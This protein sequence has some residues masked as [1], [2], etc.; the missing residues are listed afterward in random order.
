[1]SRILIT[2]AEGF[3]GHYLAAALHARGH[4]V[5]G[6]VQCESPTARDTRSASLQQT[7]VC[8]LLDP[9]G[10]SR[11]V[12]AVRPDKV[13][14]LA[15]IAFVGHGDVE[16]IYR[17]N[18]VGT[19]HLLA[20]LA[21]SGAPL[22]AVLLAS[23]AHVYGN[24]YGNVYA[25]VAGGELDESVALA[26]ANDYAVSKLAMEYMARTWHEH[27]PITIV[28]PFNYTGIGQSEDYLLPK[29]VAHFRRRAPLIELGNLDVERDFSD[30][31]TVVE[32]YCRLLERQAAHEV[33]N[34]CSGRGQSL[35]GVFE[36]VSEMAGYR[37]EVRMNP[38]FVRA[39]EVLRLVGSKAALDRCIGPVAGPSIG[40]TLAWMFNA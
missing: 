27:L 3:T 1:M 38:A 17:V 40:E 20:A 7:H 32:V 11:V 16:A 22:T 35:R 2:G 13:A 5:H 23:S 30:V 28:R 31:R 19:R 8:D 12:N 29:I 4:E 18:V 34:V 26:P 33:F 37:P 9:I 10:L 6:L 25:N 21:S 14:H 24:V 39:N 15:G 36:L